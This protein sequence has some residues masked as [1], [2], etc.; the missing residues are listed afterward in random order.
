MLLCA[1]ELH[2]LGPLWQGDL[3]CLKPRCMILIKPS[4]QMIWKNAPLT[5]L[6]PKS[7]TNFFRFF[8]SCWQIGYHHIDLE[9]IMRYNWR[10]EKHHHGDHYIR[11]PEQKWFF[12][13]NGSRWICLQGVFANHLRLWQ[14]RYSSQ[15][16][17][18]AVYDFVLIIGTLTVRQ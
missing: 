1:K 15:R 9:L 2:F 5:S 17:Q 10:K 7:I 6:F 13:R 14:L 11:C 12:R 8:V 3:R 16:S 4:R 18:E